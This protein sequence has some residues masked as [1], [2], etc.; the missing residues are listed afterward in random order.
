MITW[1]KM[2]AEILAMLK[3]CHVDKIDVSFI[4]EDYVTI[5]LTTSMLRQE[6]EAGV[7]EECIDGD[8]H[9]VRDV[10]SLPPARVRL[11]EG[12]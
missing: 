5:I 11:E 4:G 6:F 1:A 7:A 3:P 10:P 12:Q 9:L 2:P 8:C